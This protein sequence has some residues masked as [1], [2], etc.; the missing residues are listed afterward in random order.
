MRV[1]LP[2]WKDAVGV[3]T[4]K[5]WVIEF[6]DHAEVK[7]RVGSG[8]QDKRQGLALGRQVMRLV[9]CKVS[10]EQPDAALTRWIEGLPRKLLERLAAIDLL[11]RRHLAASNPLAEHVRDWRAALLAKGVTARHADLV[12]GRVKRVFDGCGFTYWSNLS[13]SRVMAFLADLRAD[14]V[15]EGEAKRGLDRKSVV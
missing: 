1:Y 9:G 10:G 13:G 6:T 7:R 2:K 4:A 8:M 15:V 12:A 14:R 5:T 11:D 3:H